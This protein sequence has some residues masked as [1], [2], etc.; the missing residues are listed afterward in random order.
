M[1]NEGALGMR[2]KRH[3]GI[4]RSDVSFLLFTPGACPAFRSGR[5]QGIGHAGKNMPCPSSAMSSGRLFLDRGARQHCPSPLHRQ[6]QDKTL[7]HGTETN[8]H[9]TARCGLTGCLTL[10]VHFINQQDLPRRTSLPTFPSVANSIFAR[11]LREW[12]P[13]ALVTVLP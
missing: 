11:P 6:G 5:C 3:D 9:R 13:L 2:F 1:K 7:D 10:G 8:Y 12:P 4:Y